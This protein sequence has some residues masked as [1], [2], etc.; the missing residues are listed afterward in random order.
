VYR[1]TATS[2][3]V[4]APLV[5]SGC[6]YYNTFYN[7][8]VAA[9][10]ADSLRESRAPGAEMTTKERDLLERVVEKCSAVIRDHP[11]SAWADDALVLMAR[12]LHEQGKNEAAFAR[13]TE[14]VVRF[15]E[16]ELR[17][18]ADY[19]T[20]AVLIAK[21]DPV[22]A[23][24]LLRSLAD[25]DPPAR[26]SDDALVLIGRARHERGRYEDAAEAY[27][28]A[29]ERFPNGDRRAEARV[30]AAENYAD[31]GLLDQA[32]HQYEQV[33]RERATAD[34]AFEARARLA[35]ARIELGD[36]AGALAVL[37]DLERRTADR[38]RLDR[39]LL[40]QGRVHELTGGLEDAVA[41]YEGVAASHARSGAS[42]MAL[43]RIGL[44]RRD[45]DE[46]VEAA[47]DVLGKARD[48]SPQSEAGALAS[49]AVDELT[50][51]KEYLAVIDGAARGP[52]PEAAADSAGAA[53]PD[54][55]LFVSWPTEDAAA[56]PGAA[57]DTGLAEPAAVEGV[58]PPHS[59]AEE[60]PEVV[61]SAPPDTAREA[62]VAVAA[63]DE[64]VAR[65]RFLLAELYLFG[66]DRPEKA[67]ERYRE[68]IE[69]HPGSAFA[70]KAGLA[71]AWILESRLGDP[72]GA[73]AAYADV[74]ARHPD[75]DFADS[76]RD[77]LARLAPAVQT[78]P[79]R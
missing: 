38:D 59:G 53:S 65:A 68:V 63:P 18:E 2:L 1:R 9:R 61:A 23:E 34:L 67:L 42:A 54:S 28:S 37:E 55:G 19:L 8:R 36:A 75:T 73:A 33:S 69:R 60:A 45:R 27:M 26:L 74:A 48:E 15:P 49:R 79:E 40:L 66:M 16:S 24:D 32:A 14:F 29:L 13:L 5:L 70:P 58:G 3:V 25:A 39:V 11:E 47:L 4:L 71:A 12:A 46:D 30:L 64:D 52:E 21:G 31:A 41:V 78:A 76:A 17:S 22:A 10:E 44:I 77:A 50:K 43:Y 6:V 51:L 57:P 35:E 62:A 7:A 56:D 20:G 72:V